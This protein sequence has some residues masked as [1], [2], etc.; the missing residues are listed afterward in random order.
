MLRS[1]SK[2]FQSVTVVI[3][4]ADYNMIIDTMRKNNGEISAEINLKLAYKVFRTTSEYDK[5]IAE[6]LK[7]QL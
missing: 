7:D 1:A 5:M 3:D 6:Y 4:P 2:N